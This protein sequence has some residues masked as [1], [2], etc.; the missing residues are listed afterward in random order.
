MC[1]TKMRSPHPRSVDVNDLLQLAGADSACIQP[2][3]NQLTS[4]T[5]QCTQTSQCLTRE[6][7]RLQI[8]HHSSREIAASDVDGPGNGEVSKARQD[9][10]LTGI[11]EQLHGVKQVSYMVDDLASDTAV[12][13]AD[14]LK[15]ATTTRMLLMRPQH[16]RNFPFLHICLPAVTPD[17]MDETSS[18]CAVGLPRQ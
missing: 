2:S 12:N 5:Q 3:C 6:H 14:L 7:A 9:W 8:T 10:T 18:S 4:E 16:T 17:P 11:Q 1:A 15:N 13:T